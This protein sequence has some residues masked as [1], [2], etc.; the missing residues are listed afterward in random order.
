[1]DPKE[2]V[3]A[4]MRRVDRQRG[5]AA[6][7][8]AADAGGAGEESAALVVSA[9]RRHSAAGRGYTDIEPA[10]KNLELP[11]SAVAGEA[12]SLAA[13]GHAF[14]PQ[15]APML[16]HL[17]PLIVPR[18]VCSTSSAGAH[19]LA[20]EAG[21]ARRGVGR[22]GLPS[23]CSCSP[24]TAWSGRGSAARR[25]SSPAS[26]CSSS[27]A[28]RGRAGSWCVPLRR[29]VT[30]EQVA[31]YLEEHEP[32]LQA[33]LLSAVE[34]S[35]QRARRNRRRSSGASSSRRSRRARGIEPPAA[36]SGSRCAATALALAAVVAVAR[37]GVAARPGVHPQCAVGAAAD[38]AGRRSRRRRTGSR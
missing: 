19:A 13:T 37:A 18:P 5:D 31:L 16:D 10:G 20:H 24:P 8:R 15:R 12:C 29:K 32:S 17:R 25:S 23:C 30:D 4:A 9:G 2:I 22:G 36:S 6:E 7:R 3:A 34:A 26:R 21:A 1:M 33:T 38:L 14:E 28:C 11:V 27:L 35:Q